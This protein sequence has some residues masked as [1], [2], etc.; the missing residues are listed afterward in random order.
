[1]SKRGFRWILTMLLA[2]AGLAALPDPS[3]AQAA[4]AAVQDSPIRITI[5]GDSIDANEPPERAIQGWGTFLQEKLAGAQVTNLAL[6]GRSTKTYLQGD[7]DKAGK[8]GPAKYWMKA[9]ATPA[10]YWIIKFG[11]NDSHPATQDKHTD[12]P[13]YAANLKIMIDTARKLH[14]KPIL[15]T[16]FRR[17]F[18][19]GALTPELD[20]Y[21]DAARQV[22]KDENVPL[23]DVYAHA[24]EWFTSLGPDGLTQYLPTEL[25]GHMNRAGANLMAEWMA[26]QLVKI[27]PQL[28]LAAVPGNTK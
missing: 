22:A 20:V 5:L 9:Q 3:V 6:S 12:P 11:G 7:L 25:G 21:A 18:A 26:E 2:A 1:M 28:S 4:T 24:T 15:C 8:R 23:I 13:E 17:P 10:D 16:P 19:H 14:V 27:V